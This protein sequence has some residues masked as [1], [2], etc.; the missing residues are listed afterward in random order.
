MRNHDKEPVSR[1]KPVDLVGQLIDDFFADR[2][3][4]DCPSRIS[5]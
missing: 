5:V 1:I 4:D 2:L 3:T